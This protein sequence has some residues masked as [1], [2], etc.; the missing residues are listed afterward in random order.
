ME[1]KVL[2]LLVSL[3]GGSKLFQSLLD[4][5]PEV[6]GFPRTFRLTAFLGSI[7]NQ[8]DDAENISNAFIKKYPLFFDGT[9][10]KIVNKL[11]KADQLGEKRKETFKVSQDKFK[12]AFLELYNANKKNAKNLFVSL[13]CAFQIAKKGYVPEK[14]IILYHIHDICFI[15]DVE[16]CVSLFGVK[17][18]KVLLT[19]R[20][21]VGGLNSVFHWMEIQNCLIPVFN[22]PKSYIKQSYIFT[23]ELSKRIKDVDM[24]INLLEVIRAYRKEVMES[25]CEWVGISW[26]DSLMKSTIMGRK[27][28]GNTQAD[29]PDKIEE[30]KWFKPSN[31]MEKKDLQI[32]V[33]LFP[34]RMKMF[35]PSQ[36]ESI[37]NLR[38]LKFLIILPTAVEFKIFIKSLSLFYWYKCI[39]RTIKELTNREKMYNYKDRG[40]YEKIQYLYLRFRTGNIITCFIAYV[41]RVKYLLSFVGKKEMS[42]KRDLLFYPIEN[43]CDRSLQKI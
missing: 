13:N 21:P 29:K 3:R 18:V 33:T 31:W 1:S 20:H 42:E 28:L 9:L 40:P 2:C 32:Y 17:N 36:V 12:N 8:I 38:R 10:W 5:H 39:S 35:G 11:D 27:W 30:L 19:T 24:R 23:S 41:K 16:Q 14:Y 6:I 25:L 43:S 37:G 22:N 15:D 7:N 26:N 4:D 34:D